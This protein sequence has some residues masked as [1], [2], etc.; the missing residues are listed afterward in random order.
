MGQPKFNFRLQQV[1]DT[2]VRELDSVKA[3]MG[4]IMQHHATLKQHIQEI[5]GHIE[6]TLNT[7]MET[8]Q[9]IATMESLNNYLH[10]M[11]LEKQKRQH[12]LEHHQR[13]VDQYQYKLRTA[14]QKQKVLETLKDKQHADFTKK[15]AT[16][17]ADQLEEIALRRYTERLRATS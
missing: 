2:R 10:T 9:D 12:K 17:E 15:I 16:A 8:E 6:D 11:R 3:E 5:D 7:P 13:I 14:Y 4:G 1:L